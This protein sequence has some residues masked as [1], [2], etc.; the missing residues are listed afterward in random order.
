MTML[1]CILPYGYRPGFLKQRLVEVA[2]QYYGVERHRSARIETGL[3]MSVHSIGFCFCL[4]MLG[5]DLFKRV[6][7]GLNGV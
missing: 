7:A 3:E 6:K 2:L 4:T 1:L 5:I